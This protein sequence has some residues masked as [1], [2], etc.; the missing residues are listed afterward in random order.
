MPITETF[1]G[2][3][4]E[5]DLIA[6]RDA[7]LANGAVSCTVRRIGDR[8]IMTT[9]WGDIAGEPLTEFFPGTTSEADLTAERDDRLANGARSCRFERRGGGWVMYTDWGGIL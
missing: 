5:P 3:T 8:W 7:R 9:D 6:E 1:P 2:T 4:P